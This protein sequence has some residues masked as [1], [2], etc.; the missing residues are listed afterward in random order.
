MCQYLDQAAE[1]IGLSYRRPDG[2]VFLWVRLPPE[3]DVNRLAK[4]TE[5]Q[6]VSFM[7]GAM[8]FPGKN[9]GGNYI[10]L[11]YS[12]PTEQQI[13]RGMKILVRAMQKIQIT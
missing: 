11:N 10:R 13:E 5:R 7:P 4:E 1:S 6:G 12:Y 3:L 8:F 2:G 9:P